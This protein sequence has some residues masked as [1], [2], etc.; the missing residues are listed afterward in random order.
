MFL[1]LTFPCR[2][3]MKTL[4]W[5]AT[6]PQLRLLS[7]FDWAS[8]HYHAMLQTFFDTFWQGDFPGKAKYIFHRYYA[9]IR[10][11]VP[12]ENLLEYNI[13][14]GWEPL[15]RFLGD[16]IPE[17]VVFPNVNDT[18]MFVRRCRRR[19]MKQMLNVL[20]RWTVMTMVAAM[21][22]TVLRALLR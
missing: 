3:A 22:M 16:E 17:G 8:S 21:L 13:S 18:D 1:M 4:H 5:R 2:S 11:I 19:N 12:P 10:A 20:F 15:C 6:E 7:H 14:Q 9:E